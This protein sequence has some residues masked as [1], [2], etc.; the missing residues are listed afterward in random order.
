MTITF[1]K[2][3]AAGIIASI[4]VIPTIAPAQSSGGPMAISGKLPPQQTPIAPVLAGTTAI[5]ISAQRFWE[6]WQRASQDA[7]G[8]PLMR[9]LIG[10]ALA[11][12]RLQQM[13]FVQRA[14]TRR[15]QWRSDATQWGRHDYWA[16]AEE[17]LQRGY[18]D[19]EDRAIVKMQ[20]LRTLGVSPRDLY[21]TLARD[22]VG[23]PE[24]V[25]V[26]RDGTRLYILDDTGGPP[27][28]SSQ[29][30]EFH[31][32]MSFGFGASW[33][34]ASPKIGAAVA[35]ATTTSSDGR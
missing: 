1:L 12:T 4:A 20:A 14:V 26:V 13:A 35:A 10:P 34:H 16:S 5:R 19:M 7:S 21:F 15:I 9:Q 29:R 27:Y 22:T 23:G 18:G 30:P 32:V 31:P 11:L 24:A 3:I 28:T 2:T 25:L 6:N 17:T 33:V 8:S